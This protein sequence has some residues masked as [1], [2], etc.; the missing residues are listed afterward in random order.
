M[1]KV[2]GDGYATLYEKDGTTIVTYM[3]PSDIH[4]VERLFENRYWPYHPDAVEPKVKAAARNAFVE[5]WGYYRR[6]FRKRVHDFERG[7]DKL[8]VCHNC[9][10]PR[11]SDAYCPSKMTGCDL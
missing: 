1:I 2:D 11:F 9:K 6:A 5:A 3:S 8:V 7:H 4:I 10:G